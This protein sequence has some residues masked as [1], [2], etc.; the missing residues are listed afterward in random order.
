[1]KP[2]KICKYPQ[3]YHYWNSNHIFEMDNL[4]YLERK[5]KAKELADKHNKLNFCL[6]CKENKKSPFGICKLCSEQLIV[7]RNK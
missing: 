4:L 6:L 5:L 7:E 2:C 3:T 1:M